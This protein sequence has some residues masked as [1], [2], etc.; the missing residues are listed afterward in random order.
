MFFVP[1]TSFFYEVPLKPLLFFWET[2]YC[3][4]KWKEKEEEE[5]SLS[6]RLNCQ[7]RRRR[8]RIGMG[9]TSLNNAARSYY[10]LGTLS[11]SRRVPPELKKGPWDTAT[12]ARR[13]T[14]HHVVHTVDL[15]YSGLTVLEHYCLVFTIIINLERKKLVNILCRSGL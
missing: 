3:Q 6:G 9:K 2:D 8:R 5:G 10:Y 13:K 7:A 4:R 15:G 11:L 12:P 1:T 14:K